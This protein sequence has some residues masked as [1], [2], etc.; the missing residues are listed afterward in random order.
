M[1]SV[2]KAGRGTCFQIRRGAEKAPLC[3]SETK[4][5]PRDFCPLATIR[6]TGYGKCAPEIGR[7]SPK[8]LE[9]GRFGEPRSSGKLLFGYPFRGG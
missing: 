4:V 1:A 5:A 2:R 7:F 3:S 6:I 9:I 8:T